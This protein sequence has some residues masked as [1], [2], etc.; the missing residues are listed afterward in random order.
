MK[1][2]LP[3]R[4]GIGRLLLDKRFHGSLD[5]ASRGQM[6]GWRNDPQRSAGYVAMERFEGTL[7]GRAGGFVMQ[8]LGTMSRGAMSL[9]IRIV[10]DSGSGALEGIAGTMRIEIAPGGAHTY[11]LDYTLG[12]G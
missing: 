1:S 12:A 6:L 5:G 10:P 8:H 4:D 3:A 2:R 7:D 11:L 9:E